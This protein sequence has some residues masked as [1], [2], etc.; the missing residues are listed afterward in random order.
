M[1]EREGTTGGRGRSWLVSAS[2]A[3]LLAL[4]GWGCS[5]NESADAP[6]GA[7]SALAEHAPDSVIVRL[8]APAASNLAGVAARVN[9]AFDD[10]DGDGRSDRFAHIANGELAVVKL[11]AGSDVAAAIE[12]LGRDP[13]VLYAEPN[14][15]VRA[16][17]TPNDP[18]F[19][20]LVG[21]DN[22]GQ[23][24]G[25]P[26]ADIGAVAAWDRETGSAGIVVAVI[27][28]GV[29]YSHEDLAAN[30]W[31]NPGEIP[32]NRADD[33]GNGV[34]DDVHGFN[35]LQRNGNP[36]DDHF[37]GTHCA[38]TIG[39][40][41]DN[42]IG[43][44][45]VNWQ[46][47]IMAIKFLDDTGFGT[48]EDAIASVDY[49][50]AQ[51]NAGINLRVLSNSWGGT[52]FSQGLLDAITAA[53][54]ADLLFVAAAG[55]AASD[56]DLDPIYP[57]SYEAP[58]VVAV[59]ATD[60]DDQLA[61]FS[62]FGAESVD[63]GAPG[64]DVL[65]TM[66][67]Q[68]YELLSGTSMATPHVAG[69]AAL[70]LSVNETLTTA[71][72]KDLLLTTGDP[73]PA[74]EGITV[75]G[76]RLDAASLL[77]QVGSPV[78]RFTLGITPSRTV[79]TQGETAS[80]AIDVG[81]LA[82]FAGD[83]ALTVASDP[84]IEATLT[85]TPSVTAP[86]AGELTAATSAATAAGQYRLT[87][88]GHSG[89]QVVTRS[90]ALVV[91]APGDPLFGIRI[92][93]AEDDVNRSSGAN[94]AVVVDS[95]GGAGT[96]SLAFTSSPPLPDF[97][98]DRQASIPGRADLFIAARCGTPLGDYALTVSGT[99]QAGTSVNAT[100]LLTVRPF[101]T[102]TA[103]LES[104]DTPLSI[105]DADPIGVA[106]A[107]EVGEDETIVELAVDVEITHP[108][109]GDL[110]VQLVAPDGTSV[111]LHDREG[112]GD[113]DIR[114]SFSVPELEGLR[115]AG[116]WQLRVSDNAASE[117]GTL[118]RWGLHMTSAPDGIAPIAEFVPGPIDFQI[119]EFFDSSVAI[120][121]AGD[122]ENEL[123]EWAWD[124]GDGTGSSESNPIH[125]YAE[126]GK[127]EVTLTVTDRNGRTGSQTQIVAVDPAPSPI[128][129]SIERITR[130]RARLEFRVDLRWSGALGELVELYRN[131]ALVD[132]PDNDDA[133]RDVFRRY[134]TAYRWF[135]CEQFS[136]VCSN[137]VQV[138][139]GPDFAGERAT[140]T[141]RIEGAVVVRTIPIVDE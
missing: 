135:V 44:A 6:S 38:G 127:Y 23:T 59:A 93:P 29:D 99:D 36:F 114:Q 55:N 66:P 30:M 25:T 120:G 137:E 12:E 107:I 72:L 8:R 133:H 54:E 89:E 117:V 41:G 57:A 40:V 80:F 58:S 68:S 11:P 3:A 132:I 85:I 47:Q 52:G 82:G 139:F 101:A 75:S 10:A 115:T 15:I 121:C 31:V 103:V 45:G 16:L 105:P 109:V 43:V 32:G 5:S 111:T 87:V 33:D 98:L 24:G 92:S 129:L 42:G 138:D 20:E 91:R 83:V 122:R 100:A 79:V 110:V 13:D 81:T 108:S 71:E 51:Q 73:L 48:I 96:V 22:T 28:T 7:Q 140:V 63:L 126:P 128:T 102:D 26:G 113:D 17:A 46:T 116:T 1:Q 112:G 39:A 19:P 14:Y 9:G 70:A 123:V 106:S 69:A 84:A 56:N 118:A 62:N 78:P 4:A 88:T 18:R 65:S 77:E 94:L 97:E 134:E 34:V 76:R 60:H 136:V 53:G 64:V 74:L 2:G 124:F 50:I 86:G 90:I 67:G 61:F 27:D 35:A 37:H 119:I 95:F 141:E 125:T 130:N 131:E 21:L 104:A 49:A